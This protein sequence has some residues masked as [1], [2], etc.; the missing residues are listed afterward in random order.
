MFLTLMSNQIYDV[1]YVLPLGGSL[2]TLLLVSFSAQNFQFDVID[3][4]LAFL[5]FG[6]MLK[7]LLPNLVS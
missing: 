5:A 4:S 2:S 1:K 6:A 7:K 3:F